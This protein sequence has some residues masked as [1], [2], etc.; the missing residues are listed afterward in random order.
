MAKSNSWIAKVLRSVV[1]H[2]HL[3][4]WFDIYSTDGIVK[5]LLNRNIEKHITRIMND[6]S[7]SSAIQK[8]FYSPQLLVCRAY[9][10]CIW[11]F[12]QRSPKFVNYVYLYIK[13]ICTYVCIHTKFFIQFT[14]TNLFPWTNL[15]VELDNR[16]FF[17]V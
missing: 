11:F 15:S 7:S 2:H 16:P 1:N 17:L 8:V 5:G 6:F 12:F 13:Y 4:A 3:N 14:L 10:H 9:M